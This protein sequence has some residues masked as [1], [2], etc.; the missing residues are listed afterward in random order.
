M[1]YHLTYEPIRPYDIPNLQAMTQGT[2]LGAL[3]FN[4]TSN[5]TIVARHD[6]QMVGFIFG[7]KDNEDKLN[8]LNIVGTYLFS[9]FNDATHHEKLKLALIN[10]AKDKLKVTHYRYDSLAKPQ[11]IAID[12][13]IPPITIE[14]QRSQNSTPSHTSQQFVYS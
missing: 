4:S 1:T 9:R 14:N 7:H 11:P 5:A 8:T 3:H 13:I 10:W 2:Q 12:N 6:G